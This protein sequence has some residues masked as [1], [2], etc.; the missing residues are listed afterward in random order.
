MNSYGFTPDS[1]SSSFGTM[2]TARNLTI[3]Y[4]GQEQDLFQTAFAALSVGGHVSPEVKI[5]FDLSGFYTNER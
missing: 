3:Y 1:M 4:D 2:Q 5:G